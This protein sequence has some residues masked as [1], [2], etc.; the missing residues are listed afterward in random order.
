MIW[1]IYA[2][3][4]IYIMYLR[5]LCIIVYT[6]FAVAIIDSSNIF[7]TDQHYLSLLFLCGFISVDLVCAS[8]THD[9]LYIYT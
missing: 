5:S 1:Y 9:K 2:Y 8:S 4:I 6:M 3:S 7:F